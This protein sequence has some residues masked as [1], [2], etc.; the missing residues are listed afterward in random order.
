MVETTTIQI[1]KEIKRK[2]ETLKNHK[3]ETYD[4]LLTRFLQIVTDDDSGL[5]TDDDLLEIEQSMK[6]LKE[7]KYITNKQLRKELGL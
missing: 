6:D 1:S 7:G 4:A 3:Q 2:L 5:L